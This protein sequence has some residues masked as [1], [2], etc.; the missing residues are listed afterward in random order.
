MLKTMI[1]V[2]KNDETKDVGGRGRQ[3]NKKYLLNKKR[4]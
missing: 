2:M 4:S 1:V 3:S